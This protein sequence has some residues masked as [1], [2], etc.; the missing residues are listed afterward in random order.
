MFLLFE[1]NAFTAI[2]CIVSFLTE[3]FTPGKELELVANTALA[4]ET[5]FCYHILLDHL[6]DT[7]AHHAFHASL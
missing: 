3:I 5:I 7:H 2:F 4:K 6:V 1:K